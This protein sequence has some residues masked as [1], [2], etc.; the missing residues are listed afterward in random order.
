MGLVKKLT[1]LG[2][3]GVMRAVI[4]GPHSHA[5]AWEPS[6]TRPEERRRLAG[7]FF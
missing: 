7:L 6:I 4:P 1:E 3:N 5:G 2:I